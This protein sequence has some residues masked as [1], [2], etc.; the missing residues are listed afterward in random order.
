[1]EKLD[2]EAVID[3]RLLCELRKRSL[4][5]KKTYDAAASSVVPRCP[6]EMTEAS[7]NDHSAS[8]VKKTG[9]DRRKM[10]GISAYLSVLFETDRFQKTYLHGV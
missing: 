8:W 1:M 10:I 3:A 6:I 9:R 2:T 4:S 5:Q 7:T